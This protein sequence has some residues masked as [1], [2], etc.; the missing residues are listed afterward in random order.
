MNSVPIGSTL[1]IV[2]FGVTYLCGFVLVI[3]LGAFLA[4]RFDRWLL[5]RN[6]RPD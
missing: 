2:A 4:I 5:S 1:I 6:K 3:A